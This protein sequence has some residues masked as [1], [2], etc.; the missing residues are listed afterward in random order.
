M[1]GGTLEA[2]LAFAARNWRVFPCRGKLPAISKDAGGNGCLDATC[3][4]ATITGWWSSDPR[5]NIGIATGKAS[6]FFAVDLDQKHDGRQALAELEEEFGYLPETVEQITP[7]GG[8]HVLFRYPDGIEIRNSASRIR[9][10]IDVRGTGGYI[11][12]APSIHPNGSAYRWHHDLHPDLIPIAAAPAWLLDLAKVSEPEPV[13]VGDR[14][15]GRLSRY[16]EAAL[17]GAVR[18]I[19]TA[20]PGAQETTLNSEAYSIGQLAGGGVIPSGLC[21]DSL[22]WAARQMSS[23]D[24]RRPWRQTELDRKVR[25]AFTDG[26]RRPRG[27]PDAA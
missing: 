23:H 4:P 7:T 3:D 14:P 25:A 22:L 18:R 16:A 9:P 11:L 19:L 15:V 26:L 21:V 10:G 17:D 12:A 24:K 13:A 5:Y 27:V 6:G 2:A 1:S 20:G 8:R